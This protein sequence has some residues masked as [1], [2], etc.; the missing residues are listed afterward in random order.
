MKLN[1]STVLPVILL[2]YLGGMAIIGYKSV[3]TGET[4]L[5]T[6]I[7]TIVV[8]LALIITLHFFL[9]KREKLRNERLRDIENNDRNKQ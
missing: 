9:K 7:L 6:Y 8:T 1:R 3:R 5:T 4:S 2:V